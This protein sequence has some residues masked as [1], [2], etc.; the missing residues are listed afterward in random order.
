[1]TERATKGEGVFVVPDNFFR[2]NIDKSNEPDGNHH[3][4]SETAAV[5]VCV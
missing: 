1:M 2:H 5:K 4:A 3:T